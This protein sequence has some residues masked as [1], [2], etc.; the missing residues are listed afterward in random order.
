MPQIESAEHEPTFT[1]EA[2]RQ[3]TKQGIA[4]RPASRGQAALRVLAMVAGSCSTCRQP[5][6][7]AHSPRDVSAIYC[8]ACCPSCSA[9]GP[10]GRSGANRDR[11]P[12]LL[13]EKRRMRKLPPEEPITVKTEFGTV[14]NTS[15]AIDLFAAMLRCVEMEKQ[16][17]AAENANGCTDDKPSTK[18]N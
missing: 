15:A 12:N 9:A 10:K 18:H 1:S 6:D 2:T 7:G 16:R 5:I 4:A 13:G 14:N 8:A 17:I 11:V 3:G